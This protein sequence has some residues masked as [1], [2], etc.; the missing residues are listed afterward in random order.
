MHG[1]TDL[2]A[3]KRRTAALAQL[4]VDGKPGRAHVR[5][6]PAEVAA[7]MQW[8][9]MPPRAFASDSGYALARAR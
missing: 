4:T 1:V 7:E 2:D 3:R 5:P 9:L 6:E 8:A